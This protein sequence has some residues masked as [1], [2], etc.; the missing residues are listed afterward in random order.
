[1]DEVRK[2]GARVE[3]AEL[4][5]G[6]LEAIYGERMGF[7]LLIFPLGKPGTADYVCNCQRPEMITTLREVADRL[8]KG[9]DIPAPVGSG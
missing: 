5:E 3:L 8:E 1:M 4:N 7:A 9:Q 2:T 6:L